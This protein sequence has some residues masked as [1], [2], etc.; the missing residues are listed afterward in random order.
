MNR[1]PYNGNLP[2]G[3]SDN[4]PVFSDGAEYTED[5]VNEI[6]PSFED[7]QGELEEAYRILSAAD[8]CG[9]DFLKEIKEA[10]TLMQTISD[11]LEYARGKLEPDW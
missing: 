1:L 7:I 11:E 10:A 9:P 4:H 8:T 5:E 2:H 3:V 6:L